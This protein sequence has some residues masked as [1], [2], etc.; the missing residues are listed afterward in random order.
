MRMVLV[1]V[2]MSLGLSFGCATE[3]E[4]LISDDGLEQVEQEVG[5]SCHAHFICRLGERCGTTGRCEGYAVFG[6]AINPCMDT[7]QCQY[8]WALN[9]YCHRPVWASYGECKPLP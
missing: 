7:E 9:S 2:F 3:G 5:E 8:Q 1:L 6:P 4:E